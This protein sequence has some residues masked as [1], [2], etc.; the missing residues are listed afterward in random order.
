MTESGSNRASGTAIILEITAAAD[1]S[2]DLPPLLD[3]LRNIGGTAAS[4]GFTV[5][6]LADG[7]EIEP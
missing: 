6:L 3:V 1:R 7:E 4:F 2:E 5:R